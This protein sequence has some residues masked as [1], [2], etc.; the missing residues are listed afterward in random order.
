MLVERQNERVFDPNAL[1]R[2]DVSPPMPEQNGGSGDVLGAAFRQENVIGSFMSQEMLPAGDVDLSFNAWDEIQGTAYEPHWQRFAAEA[3]NRPRSEALMRQIDRETEDRRTV[4]SAGGWGILASLGAGLFSPENL[5][6]GGTVYRGV[7][8]GAAVLKTGLSTASAAAIAAGAAE[9]GLQSTQ[10]TRT[11]MESAFA[12]GGSAILGGVLGAGLARAFSK[13]D[14]SRYAGQLSEELNTPSGPDAMLANETALRDHVQV[15]QAADVGA[16]AAQV[17]DIEDLGIDPAARF[18]A[19]PVANLNPA[20]RTATSPSRVVRETGAGLLENGFY[21]KMNAEG[22]TIGPGVESLVKEYELGA[23]ARSMRETDALYSEY[24]KGGGE[25]RDRSL[26][27]EA[28]GRAMRRGDQGSD[29][30]ISSAARVWRERVFDPLK[31][32][33][34]KANLLPADVSVDTALSYFTRV[35]NAPRLIAEEGRFK[36]IVRGWLDGQIRSMETRVDEIK[37]GNRLIEYEQG[38]DRFLRTGQRL[39]ELD[40]RIGDRGRAR[41]QRLGE[42]GDLEQRRIDAMKDR[43]P[44]EVLQLVRGADQGNDFVEAVKSGRGAMRQTGR[45]QTY[46]EKYPVLAAIKSRGGVRTGSPLASE[47]RARGVTPQTHPGLFHK[48]SGMTDLDNVPLDEFLDDINDL[49]GRVSGVESDGTFYAEQGSVLELIDD[50]LAGSPFRTSGQLETEAALDA[51]ADNARAWLEAVGLP[52][53]ATVREVRD[54]I[55]RARQAEREYES[56]GDR[57][58]R[59]EGDLAKFDDA[60]DA[61]R[62][63]R[64]IVESE[65]A[66]ATALVNKLEADIESVRELGQAS[67]LVGRM[68]DLAD[69]KKNLGKARLR[70]NPIRK[71]VAEL[72]RA[73]ADGKLTDELSAELNAKEIDFEAAMTKVRTYE[74]RVAKLEPMVPKKQVDLPDFVSAADREAYIEDIADQVFNTLTGRLN[75]GDVPLNV[76]MRSKNARGPL[77]ERTFNIPDELIEDFLESNVEAVGRRYARIMAADVELTRRFGSANMSDTIKAVRDE[78]NALRTAVEADDAL[79]AAQR[80]NKLKQLDKRE[81]DDIVDVEALRDLIRGTYKRRE[82]STNYARVARVAGTINYLRALGGVTVSSLT[83]VARHVM[84]HGL[85][86]VM[87]D[88]IVPLISNIKAAGLSIEEAR[89]AGAVTERTLNTR[90][91]TWADLTDPYSFS[92]PFEKFMENTAAGFSRVNGLVYWNDFQKSFASIITQNRILR[93]AVDGAKMSKRN[94]NYMAYLGIDDDVAAKIAEQFQKHGSIE[95]G[96]VRVAG[97]DLWDSD[98]AAQW[99]KRV[100]RAALNKD[101]DTTIITKGIGDVPLFANTPTGRLF[102][103]FKGFALAS[104]QRALMRGLSEDKAGFVSGMLLASTVGMMIYALKSFES[105]RVEDISDNPGRWIAEGVDRSGMLALAFEANNTIEKSLG[106]GAYGALAALF[107]NA[108]QDGKASRYMVRSTA[109][110]LAGPTADFIDTAV[111]GVSA[112]R[113]AGTG[114]G[115]TEGD[116]NA[117]RR[118]A[119]GASLPGIRSFIEYIGIPA[120]VEALN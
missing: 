98:P 63:E 87:R 45:K 40:Q 37:A 61:L 27:M 7:R 69:A 64:G 3:W 36:G 117:F 109:A 51:A 20:L 29:P 34:I 104:H 35:Y 58:T 24:R 81:K 93:N 114:E 15:A 53:G 88:G 54:F 42:I 89:I 25:I 22:R 85:D 108:D 74:E 101:I 11:G 56:L 92:S 55:R 107:P 106:I 97:T 90:L 41:E 8:T 71:R 19:A 111:R 47:L 110:A 94:R 59:L 30:A 119:P 66:E 10:V 16:A 12:V 91:A 83:D 113:D 86:G 96:G 13:Q 50:E 65:M 105:N 4:D 99:A 115:L 60:T 23:V 68:L 46:A 103:Q 70:A 84:V 73:E 33:A 6:P 76:T 116:I 118:L 72:Q 62:G 39:E 18:A 77:E 5:L 17:S 120:A 102:L 112:I 9:V 14:F 44:R 43:A 31:E 67:P 100:Y 49:E 75:D 78:Y 52:E 21:L 82:N 2:L 26:F 28:V 1:E 80:E 38:R 48:K 79:T 95:E 32:E 57:I